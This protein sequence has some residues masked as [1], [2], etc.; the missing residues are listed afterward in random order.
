MTASGR[1]HFVGLLSAAWALASCASPNPNLYTIAPVPGPTVAS[2][3]KIVVL[4]SI[5][6]ARYL[7]RREIV[8]SS[9]NYRVEVMANDWWGEPIDLMIARVLVQEL[10]DRLSQST[11]YQATGAV[12]ATPD[13]S[14]ELELQ[15]LDL[16]AAGQLVLVAQ[17]AVSSEPRGPVARRRFRIAVTPPAATVAGQVAASSIALGQMADGIAEMLTRRPGR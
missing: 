16:D 8:R 1:R 4:R 17:A 9:E 14:I 10:G 13:A 12:S 5:G 6:V 3:P 7:I 2:S 15:R 11:V